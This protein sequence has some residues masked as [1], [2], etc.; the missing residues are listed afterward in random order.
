[1]PRALRQRQR[2]RKDG[3]GEGGERLKHSPADSVLPVI[4]SLSKHLLKNGFEG[5]TSSNISSKRLNGIISYLFMN[6]T[7]PPFSLY[8]TQWKLM[9]SRDGDVWGIV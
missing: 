5:L 8:L 7:P 9:E 3:G 1:M 2:G 6:A 4:A